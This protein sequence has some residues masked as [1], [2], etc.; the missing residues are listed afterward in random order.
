MFVR[1]SERALG[2]VAM[3]L[4]LVCL[5]AFG[6]QSGAPTPTTATFLLGGTT[7]RAVEIEGRATDPGVT[8]TL[9]FEGDQ[10]VSGSSGCN[11]YTAPLSVA[12]SSIRVG[13]IAM[14]RM[15]CPPPAM[16]QE[17]RFTAA[18]EAARAFRQERDVLRLLDE[19]G[20]SVLR[21]ARA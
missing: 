1:R 21:F 2:R 5:G 14:T 19:Q 10:R 11:R 15:A 9:A 18:L 3:G 4:A 16:D 6:C 17:S 8:S 13:A 12:G 20:R 7:W